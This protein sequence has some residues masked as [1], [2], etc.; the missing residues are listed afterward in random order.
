LVKTLFSRSSA[1]LC[2]VTRF[3]QRLD[4]ATDRQR[5]TSSK[6]PFTGVDQIGMRLLDDNARTTTAAFA[7]A[8]LAIDVLAIALLIVAIVAS[9]DRASFALRAGLVAAAFGFGVGTALQYLL[10]RSRAAH[11]V[12]LWRRAVKYVYLATRVG[13]IVFLLVIALR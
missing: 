4:V 1:S 7:A 13:V 12:S 6:Y 9:P 3:D 2:S 8:W 11:A 10:L 5:D